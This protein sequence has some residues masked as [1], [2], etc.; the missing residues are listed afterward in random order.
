[1]NTL[2]NSQIKRMAEGSKQ[3]THDDVTVI[4]ARLL[5]AEAQLTELRGQ[6][7]EPYTVPEESLLRLFDAAIEAELPRVS[8]L[9]YDSHEIC[10]HFAKKVRAAML[11]Y[12]KAP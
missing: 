2:T 3:Y 6:D 10:I 9:Q 7:R 11:Q 8:H 5:A 4:A 1:M 12:V